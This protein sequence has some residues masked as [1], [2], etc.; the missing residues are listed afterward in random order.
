METYTNPWIFQNEEFESEKIEDNIGFVYLITSR[1]DNRKYIG[2]KLFISKR[3]KSIKGVK[4]KVKLES[5][6]KKYYGSNKELVEDVKTNG[7]ENYDRKILHLCKTKGTA[8][9]LELKEQILHD[10]LTDRAFYNDWIMCKIHRSH[11]KI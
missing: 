9:Y 6:W 11:I 10:D 4:K 1:I 7:S 8:N 2:K 5:D 3:T